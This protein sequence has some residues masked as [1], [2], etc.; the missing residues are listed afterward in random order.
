MNTAITIDN[1]E[2]DAAF[3]RGYEC[4]RVQ[5]DASEDS[6]HWQGGHNAGLNVYMGEY[7][8]SRTDEGELCVHFHHGMV[9]ARDL[10]PHIKGEAILTIVNTQGRFK[11]L[12]SHLSDRLLHQAIERDIS[13][14]V[15]AAIM[16]EIERRTAQQQAERSWFF[17]PNAA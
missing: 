17:K 9:P 15:L 1:D 4:G 12:P 8:R 3:R 14:E 2:D 11:V 16:S 13:P 6:Q 7:Q 5:G 10:P